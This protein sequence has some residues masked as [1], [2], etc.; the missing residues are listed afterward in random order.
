MFGLSKSLNKFLQKEAIILHPGPINR[1]VEIDSELADS[2]KSVILQQVRNGI[3]VR[4]AILYL[5]IGRKP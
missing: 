4:M 1:G 2:S 3:F 5:L